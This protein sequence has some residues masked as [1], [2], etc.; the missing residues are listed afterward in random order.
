M[1]ACRHH[2]YE[3]ILCAIHKELFGNTSGPDNVQFTEFRDAIWRNINT[4]QPFKT[5]CIKDQVLN[6]RREVVINSLKR[7]LSV[8][9]RKNSLPR[10]DYRECAEL[11]LMILRETPERGSQWMHPGATH[12]ARWMPSILF[13]AK[14]FAFSE[15]AGYDSSMIEKLEALC[16]FNS[17]F[18]VDKWLKASVGA[19]APY[20]DLELWHDL[21]EYRKY[22]EK[23][24]NVAI[25]ALERHFWYL[26]EECAVFSIFSHRLPDA[27]R[28]QIA[29][30]LSKTRCPKEF[31]KG[32]P[33]FHCSTA[34]HRL[35]ISS[36][37]SRGFYLDQ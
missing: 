21:N 25:N 3:R 12:H 33:T 22:D 16:M 37:R 31:E 9:D 26:T 14:M 2:V 32:H 7:I 23:V 35:S 36:D 29:R 27:E 11:M 5:L 20:N 8:P 19:D 30:C 24:A 10:D 17:L 6:R 13:P 15:Q 34:A 4:K 28:Q 1:L 18:Y